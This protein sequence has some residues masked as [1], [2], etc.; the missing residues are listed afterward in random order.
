MQAAKFN[1]KSV[2][3]DPKNCM[4]THIPLPEFRMVVRLI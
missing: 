3:V 2:E 4:R 1:M